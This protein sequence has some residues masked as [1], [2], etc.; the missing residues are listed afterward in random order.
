M[1]LL[2]GDKT[3]KYYGYCS[4][5]SSRVSWK[6]EDFYDNRLC[7]ECSNPSKRKSWD[8]YFSDLA[9]LVAT[10]S[11]CNRAHVG[12]VIVKNHRILST[13]Y[14]GS[15]PGAPHCED[16]GCDVHYTDG[17]PHCHRTI[18][19]E[20]NALYQARFHDIDVTG[21]TLYCTLIPCGNCRRVAEEY[22]ITELRYP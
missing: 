1:S 8:D 21:A 18:H 11:T 14:N 9:S 7:G 20:I 12:C 10:R 22:G 2:P 17:R 5:C 6:A 15:A 3:Q 13:G 16:V 19:A 4:K